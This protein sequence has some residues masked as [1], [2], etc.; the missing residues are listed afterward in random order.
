VCSSD[1]GIDVGTMQGK[2]VVDGAV[3]V[4]TEVAEIP[5]EIAADDPTGEAEALER[6][7]EMRKVRQRA[8]ATMDPPRYAN[9]KTNTPADW[10]DLEVLDEETGEAIKG[11]VEVDCV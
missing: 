9:V 5:L 11:V 3:D 10:C 7:A 2:R 1:L 6:K 8:D 4:L